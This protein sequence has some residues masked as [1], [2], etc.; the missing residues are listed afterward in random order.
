M[1]N[2]REVMAEVGDWGNVGTGLGVPFSKLEIRER[3]STEREKSLA[4]GDYWVNTDPDASWERLARV[5][6][7]CGKEG[8][9]A[10][11]KQYL[12]QGMC[13]LSCLLWKLWASKNGDL[14]NQNEN[15]SSRP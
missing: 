12:R 4:L 14:V 10:V 11:M 1:E 3:S 5:L 2:V 15:C 6:Y 9:L 7:Q 8:A 13:A